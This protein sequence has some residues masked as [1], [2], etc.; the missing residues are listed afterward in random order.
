LRESG[1]RYFADAVVGVLPGQAVVESHATADAAETAVRQAL[2]DTGV[3]VHLEPRQ[4]GLDL[5]DWALAIALAEPLVREAH[6]ISIYNTPAAPAFPS[7][8]R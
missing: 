2:P 8:S 1:G 4:E 3:V 6:N 5:R 7:I